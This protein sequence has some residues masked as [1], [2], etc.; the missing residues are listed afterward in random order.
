YWER[1][2][3][4]WSNEETW[5]HYYFWKNPKATK[6]E[7]QK[8]LINDLNVLMQNLEPNSKEATKALSILNSLKN[9]TI[10]KLK[11]AIKSEKAPEFDNIAPDRLRLWRVNIR[12][13]S[14]ELVNIDLHNY[15]QL[16]ATKKIKA[17]FDVL[18]EEHIHLI[19]LPPV[20]TSASK[21]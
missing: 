9:M 17:Y 15:D 14:N 1:P 4:L 2:C 3:E 19:V 18:P 7:S 20:F 16:K 6:A 21:E 12:D 13:N 8:A 10:H 11:K 5:D